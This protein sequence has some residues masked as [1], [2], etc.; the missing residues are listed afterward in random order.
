MRRTLR[1]IRGLLSVV[2]VIFI[3]AFATNGFGQPARAQASA[4]N[5]AEAY[6]HFTK[7]RVLDEQGQ[8]NEAIAEYQ[9][10]LALDPNNSLIYSEMA[11]TYYRNRRVREAV[12]AADKAIQA[13]RN[14]IEAHKTLSTIY[15]AM[16]G[17]ANNQQP[18]PQD[19]LNRAVREF[20]EIIRIDP[21][22][23]QSYMMLGQL[24]QIRN[25]PEKAAEIYKKY[26]GIE[27]GSEQGII[28]LAKL[29]LDAGNEREAAGLLETF[30]RE[31]PDSDAA[32]ATL[33]QAYS[34]LQRFEEAA[35]A[36]KK[37]VEL[38]PDDLELKKNYAQSLFFS[39]QL[40]E[41]A[42][43]YQALQRAEPEDGIA[44]LRL[45]QIYRRQM[46]YALA[47]QN[48]E[49][50]VTMFADSA[51]VQF[52]FV[53]LER[54]EGRLPEAIARVTDILKLGERANGR[55]SEG[56]KQNRRIFLTNLALLNT[57]V[58]NHGAA[59]QAFTELKTISSDTDRIDALIAEAY[60]SAKQID[61][62]LEYSE[63]ALK[64]APDSRDLL[65]T[66]ADLIAEKGRVD[67][68]IR[69]LQRLTR[70]NEGDL[71]VF[72]TMANIYSRARKWDQAQDVVNTA[73]RRFPENENVYL[74]QGSLYE[75]Q[76]KFNEAERAFRKALEIEKDS[77]AVLNY[78]GYILADRGLK[79][80]EAVA[81][82]HKAVETE[83]T[84]GAY[85][86]SLG[87]AYFRMNQLDRAEE[88][89]TRALIFAND[90][91]TIHDHMGDLYFKTMRYEQARTEWNKSLAIGDD[92]EEVGRIKKK[93]DG[94]KTR[95]ANR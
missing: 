47:R 18:L 45:G 72:S 4:A 3:L 12:D 88:Y 42:D 34:G 75:Q 78:L 87:W 77:P 95:I 24:Y 44:L 94:L 48:L 20:E 16:L 93:L 67:E 22:D 71:A 10:A 2:S 69:N 31:R 49:K 58:G 62:A 56:E 79:L 38:N 28:A 41:A 53:L 89:L 32:Y 76:K 90:N 5:R 33:G 6:F 11:D 57:T 65:L 83:P 84:N 9:R 64:A 35:A 40:N 70:G 29:Q 43:L 54:D 17:N 50:A 51:E 61:K 8:W 13:D 37:A 91:A 81:M 52:N 55:Y 63:Q 7:A 19:T 15:T 23:T 92:S 73:V 21:A 66:H 68:G 86:D 60:R 25:E 27:P 14:N 1:T 82:L 59:I 85:L 26:L 74:L 30:L 39:D 46:K 80:Q 36:Y